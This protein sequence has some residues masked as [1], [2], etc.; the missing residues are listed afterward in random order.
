MIPVPTTQSMSIGSDHDIGTVIPTPETSRTVALQYAHGEWDDDSDP[1]KAMDQW[2]RKGAM[3]V[4]CVKLQV[5][6]ML[7]ALN[8]GA[9]EAMDH[10]EILGA[11]HQG[12][13]F[14]S[15]FKHYGS[16]IKRWIYVQ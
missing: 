3:D 15:R 6:W 8:Q 13:S 7:H 1:S 16:G 12:A 5:R 2:A 14:W 4:A 9:T 10:E 11:I